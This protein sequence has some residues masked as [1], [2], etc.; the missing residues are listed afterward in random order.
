MRIYWH[1][2]AAAAAKEEAEAEAEA[3]AATA[4]ATTTATETETETETIPTCT[5][6]AC[7]TRT[8]FFEFRRPVHSDR[9]QLLHRLLIIPDIHQL[10]AGGEVSQPHLGSAP[11]DV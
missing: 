5:A 10:Y 4:T 7:A 1:T 8:L 2:A 9:G 3:E 6:R 11:Q